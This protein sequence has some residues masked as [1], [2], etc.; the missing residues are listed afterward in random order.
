MPTPKID[1]GFPDGTYP[2]AYNRFGY[3]VGTAVLEEPY[4]DGT[5]PV[6]TEGV[7]CSDTFGCPK[8]IAILISGGPSSFTFITT[9]VPGHTTRWD[10]GDGSPEVSVASDVSVDHDYEDGEYTITAVCHLQTATTTIVVGDIVEPPPVLPPTVPP[11]NQPP[12]A[13][14]TFTTLDLVVSYTS[15]STDPDGTLVEHNWS[16]GDG[17]GTVGNELAPTHAYAAAGTY[18]TTLT[19]TD[20][21][22]ATGSVSY[23]ATVSAPPV[24]PPYTGPATGA[25]AGPP[26]PAPGT[27]GTWTP[28]GATAPK[29]LSDLQ[30]DIPVKVTASPATKWTGNQHMVTATNVWWDGT[31]WK[32]GKAP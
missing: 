5:Y 27:A 15:T 23:T 30:N 21:Q 8:G 4:A 2:P 9:D 6:A 31:G 10:F 26:G 14:F 16:F 11:T 17:S 25:T 28:A 20:N 32:S 1:T 29:N 18:T 13:R 7:V 3:P 12:T 19:V 24:A 22:G